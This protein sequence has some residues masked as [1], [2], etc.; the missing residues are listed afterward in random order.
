MSSARV[1]MLRLALW[2]LIIRRLTWMF[3]VKVLNEL[4]RL[5]A[6]FIK[7][8]NAHRVERFEEAVAATTEK[9]KRF[10][11]DAQTF[12]TE[13]EARKQ[14]L[15]ATKSALLAE[16]KQLRAAHSRLISSHRRHWEPSR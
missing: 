7:A 12:D 16:N 11:A 5:M 13:S 6:G 1:R 2:M 8:R 4:G 9:I 15:L 14:Q 10:S 3:P